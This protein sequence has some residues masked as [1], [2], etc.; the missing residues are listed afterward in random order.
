MVASGAMIAITRALFK[1]VSLLLLQLPLLKQT[2]SKY[3]GNGGRDLPSIPQTKGPL[4][5][6]VLASEGRNVPWVSI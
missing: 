1:L 3:H 4:D 2:L 5:V 6:S